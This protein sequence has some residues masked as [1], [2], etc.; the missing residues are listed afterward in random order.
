MEI[1]PQRQLA[2]FLAALFLGV[3]MGAFRMLLS[4]LRTLA[5]AYVP[6]EGMRVRYEKQLPLLHT[7]VRFE[8]GRACLAWRA[9]VVFLTD[10]VFCLAFCVSLILLLYR[11]NDGAWRLSVPVLSIMGFA[12]FSLLSNRF[13][14]PVNT[15]L[16]E[17]SSFLAF[18]GFSFFFVFSF[19]LSALRQREKA[20]NPSLFHRGKDSVL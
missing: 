1:Y 16:P 3:R 2:M 13:F 4:A 14:H 15:V 17:N 12:L 5:G 9:T 19:R 7:G 8:R 10:L 20:V 18:K 6:P 11:F